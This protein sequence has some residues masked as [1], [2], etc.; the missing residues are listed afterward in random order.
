MRSRDSMHRIQ[1]W[2]CILY[3]PVTKVVLDDAALASV[4]I[5]SKGVGGGGVKIV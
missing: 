2:G 5:A 1:G 4:H 3:R